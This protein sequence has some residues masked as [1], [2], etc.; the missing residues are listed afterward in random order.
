MANVE[1][2]AEQLESNGARVWRTARSRLAE[3]IKTALETVSTDGNVPTE[4][5]TFVNSE[6][7]P[8]GLALINELPTGDSQAG[9]SEAALGICETGT[10]ALVSSAENPTS[11]NFLVDYHLVTVN[12]SDLVDNLQ[13]AMERLSRNNAWNARAVNFISGPSRTADIEQTIQLGAHGPR[14][15]LVFILS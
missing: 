8:E 11:L 2:F 9:L 6:D 12:E 7:F 15:L 5:L 3:C 1:Q 13:Q 14:H 10:L 4:L